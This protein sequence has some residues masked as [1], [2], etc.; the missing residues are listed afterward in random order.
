MK[1]DSWTR[2][3][4]LQSCLYNPSA[5]ALFLRITCFVKCNVHLSFTL[6]ILHAESTDT[7]NTHP[8]PDMLHSRLLTRLLARHLHAQHICSGI[9][10]WIIPTIVSN[11]KAGSGDELKL[12]IIAWNEL[13]IAILNQFREILAHIVTK[14]IISTTLRTY[15]RFGMSANDGTWVWTQFNSNSTVTLKICDTKQ[16]KTNE[17]APPI[18]ASATTCINQA[19]THTLEISTGQPAAA[20]W[21]NEALTR[22]SICHQMQ[23]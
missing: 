10:P 23:V 19:T 20:L 14:K 7:S 16:P 8:T 5:T 13:L 2:K 12:F 9:F 3:L 15:R 4:E 21:T 11:S 22:T 1:L 18:I 17:A 6:S